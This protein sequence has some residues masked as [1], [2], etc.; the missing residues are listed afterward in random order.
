MSRSKSTDINILDQEFIYESVADKMKCLSHTI[1][2][3]SRLKHK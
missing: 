1:P 3:P 2:Q